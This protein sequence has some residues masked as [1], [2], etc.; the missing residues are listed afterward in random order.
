MVLFRD[1]EGDPLL[2]DYLRHAVQDG[3]LSLPVFISTV[4]SQSG[5]LRNATLDI[6]CR[7]ALD[8]HYST[9]MGPIGSVVPFGQPSHAALDTVTQALR[10]VQMAYTIPSNQFHPFTN[11][12]SELLILLLSAVTDVSQI[13]VTQAMSF[14]DGASQLLQAFRL[15]P[16]VRHVLEDFVLSLSMVVGDE[17]AAQEAQVMHTLQIALGKGDIGG[18]NSSSTDIITC[19]LLLHA[20]V[21]REHD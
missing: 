14:L 18:A 2:Q 3:T 6:L 16:E 20:L 11:S 17:K 13:P 8:Y 12:A 21:S 1:Y 4:L 10:L 5:Q 9:G 19:G 15:S 7:L